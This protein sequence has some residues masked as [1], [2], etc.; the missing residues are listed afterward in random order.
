MSAIVNFDRTQPISNA[1]VNFECPR[2]REFVL[3]G[4]S[5]A[6]IARC[7][8]LAVK[9]PLLASGTVY[10]SL[11]REPLLKSTNYVSD[12]G[13]SSQANYLQRNAAMDDSIGGS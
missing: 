2:Q 4:C 8:R 6:A 12:V 9:V 3:R 5:L 1:S 7:P 13:S 10:A 11:F